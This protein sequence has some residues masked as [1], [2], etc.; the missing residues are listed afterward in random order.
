MMRSLISSY[1]LYNVL[2]QEVVKYPNTCNWTDPLLSDRLCDVLKSVAR[3]SYIDFYKDRRENSFSLGGL[4]DVQ[5]DSLLEVMERL[6]DRITGAITA[7]SSDYS[8]D[9][10]M[11]TSDVMFDA[12]RDK[13]NTNS[14]L[15]SR[16]YTF[17]RY[18]L[19]Q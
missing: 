10:M 12:S 8:D 13:V 15:V 16:I 3:W 18:Q 11:E 5:K 14:V 19:L 9:A 7:M 6:M 4:G 17:V 2:L 1:V